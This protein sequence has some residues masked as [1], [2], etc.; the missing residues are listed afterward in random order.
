SDSRAPAAGRG[1]HGRVR[2]RARL[3][4]DTLRARGRGRVRVPGR[5]GA[6]ACAGSRRRAAAAARC[7][8]TLVKICGL[9]NRG[10]AEA[11]LDAGADAVGMIFAP[12]SPRR[13]ELAAAREICALAAGRA[14]RVGVF[15]DAPREEVE[16]IAR[17][18]PLDVV[19]LHGAESPEYVAGVTFPAMKVLA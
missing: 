16:R 14:V 15:R 13:V 12:E 3:G 8:V 10:D 9:T 7:R 17:E 2:E 11:A 4:R 6:D 19:Q 18:L 1:P 5:G